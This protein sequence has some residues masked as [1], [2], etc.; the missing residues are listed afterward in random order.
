ML[1]KFTQPFIEIIN[2]NFDKENHY[3]YIISKSNAIYTLD[4]SN[5]NIIEVTP[6]NK[7]KSLLILLKKL[8]KS[9]KIIIHGLNSK[10]IDIVF[11][12]Q[13]WLLSKSYH[14]MWGGDF[15]FPKQ[16]SFFKKMV[17]KRMGHFVTYIKGDYDLI[18]DWYGA[19]GQYH[20]CFMYTSNLYKEFDIKESIRNS[21]KIQV[22]NSAD[23]S[24]EHFEIFEKLKKY[25]EENIVIFVPLSY[26]DKEY[27]QKVI[28]KGEEIF[29]EKFKPLVDFMEF[30]AYLDFLG[31]IDIAIFAHKRQQAMGN[32]I[33]LLG[34]GKKV[35]LRDD[36]TPWK[37]FEDLSMKIFNVE[38]IDIALISDD[39]KSKNKFLVKEYF[40]KENYLKQLQ[41]L[42]EGK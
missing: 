21:I 2:N 27:A 9:E 32:I 16:Q 24:N 20:E 6:S 19:D 40:S 4:R 29:G 31:E 23:V 17:I 14:V 22:G 30:Q 26:G 1:E 10:V 3:F 7:G 38:N 13:P 36:I 42:F 28:N 35:Y 11:F 5:E 8:Y 34:L 25:K 18:K 12:F 37:M 41:T 15:Y 39:I 33:T